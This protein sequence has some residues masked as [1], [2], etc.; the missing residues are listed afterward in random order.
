MREWKGERF[1]LISEVAAIIGRH[2]TVVHGYVQSGKLRARM[3]A[4]RRWIAETDLD[5]FL[6]P[7][8]V[9]AERMA[10]PAARER[11]A[12]KASKRLDAKGW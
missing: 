4:G 9:G 5:A 12:R 7:E 3:I 8:P 11:R 2:R 10:T 1:Y 6:C